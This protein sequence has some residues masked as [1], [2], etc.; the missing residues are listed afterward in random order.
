VR[1]RRSIDW[2]VSGPF[3]V[4]HP[5][6]F[7]FD[8]AV[9]DVIVTLSN[10][11][12]DVW[13]DGRPELADRIRV[14]SAGVDTDHWVPGGG[15]TFDVLIYHKSRDAPLLAEVEK[16]V[17]RAGLSARTIHYGAHTS[18]EYKALLQE[19]RAMV[20]L[21]LSETQGLV[22]FEAWASDVPTLVWDRRLW[23]HRNA[24]LSAP[25]SSA[26]Y[27]TDQTGM[28]FSGAED[29]PDRLH[30]F[31]THLASFSPREWVLAGHTLEHAARRY[32]DLFTR[33]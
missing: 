12:R 22:L 24:P 21:S 11:N 27:L 19:A 17:E 9:A 1:R 10:W 8:W 3:H 18:D 26:P 15:K 29:L 33:S 23:T 13:C 4:L 6:D 32:L 5:D 2:L 7:K 14:W 28:R 31:W 16:A 20:F 30:E 25:A